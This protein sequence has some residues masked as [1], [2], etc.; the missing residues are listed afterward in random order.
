LKAV[1]EGAHGVVDRAKLMRENPSC[2]ATAT[3]N[4]AP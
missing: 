4:S 2:T 1:G 3:C